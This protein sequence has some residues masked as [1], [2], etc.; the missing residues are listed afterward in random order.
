VA[1]APSTGLAVALTASTG[2]LTAC[3]A[4]SPGESSHAAQAAF[5]APAQVLKLTVRPSPGRIVF[6]KRRLEARPGKVA[7]ELTNPTPLNH[8]VRIATGS[9]CCFRPGSKDIGGT[10]SIGPGRIR[11]VVNLKPGR[12]VFYCAVGGHW[13]LGQHGTLRVR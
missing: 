7:I 9:R 4:D 3:G 11:A 12:Y 13:Q 2:L 6:D 8:N 5:W 1:M 10:N